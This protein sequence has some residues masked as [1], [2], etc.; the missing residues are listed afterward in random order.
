MKEKLLPLAMSLG[1]TTMACSSS[2]I[3][4]G[5]RDFQP[6]FNG[7]DFNICKL[8]DHVYTVKGKGSDWN[9]KSLRAN[10]VEFIRQKCTIEFILNDDAASLLAYVTVATPSCIP[11]L[12]RQGLAQNPQ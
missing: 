3:E 12:E 10:G 1:L 4:S 6:C 7:K 9:I 11:E 2:I 8:T 5:N